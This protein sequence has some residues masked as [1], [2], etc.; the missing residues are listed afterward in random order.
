LDGKRQLC[1]RR[2]FFGIKKDTSEVIETLFE[3][4][5]TLL[6]ERRHFWL[7]RE[8]CVGVETLLKRKR[9]LCHRRDTFGG[10]ETPVLA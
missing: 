9:H 5:E 10:K 3:G 8:P 1:Q 2:D 6:K 4:E 7:K